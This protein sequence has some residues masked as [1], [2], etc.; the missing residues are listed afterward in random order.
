[1]KV[2]RDDD[3]LEET[4]RRIIRQVAVEEIGKK[5]EVTVVV[6]RLAEE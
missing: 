1:A 2:M 6:S 3:K 4:V 5:P